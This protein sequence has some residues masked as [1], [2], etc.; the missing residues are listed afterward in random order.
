MK[1]SG[2]AVPVHPC[3]STEE[4]QLEGRGYYK[5]PSFRHRPPWAVLQHWPG[6]IISLVCPVQ[7]SLSKAHFHLRQWLGAMRA[8]LR[9][10]SLQEEKVWELLSLAL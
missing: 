2:V 1:D 7:A 5:G 6:G 4:A 8:V 10:A 9:L 3:S